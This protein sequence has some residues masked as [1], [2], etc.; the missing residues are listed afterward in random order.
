MS[1]IAPITQENRGRTILFAIRLTVAAAVLAALT[2][3]IP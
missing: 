3:L 1:P 2:P